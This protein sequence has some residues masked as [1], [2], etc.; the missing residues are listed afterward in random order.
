MKKKKIYEM[1]KEELL[2]ALK[3]Y[4]DGKHKK[5]WE[6]CAWALRSLN[7][8]ERKARGEDTQLA[9]AGYTGRNSNRQNLPQRLKLSGALCG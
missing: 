2:E 3:K 6:E 5:K 1:N 7:I 9:E 4:D 8:Q